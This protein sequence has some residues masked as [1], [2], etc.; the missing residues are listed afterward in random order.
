[1]FTFPDEWMGQPPP[2]ALLTSMHWAVGEIEGWRIGNRVYVPPHGQQLEYVFPLGLYMKKWGYAPKYFAF[3]K[4]SLERA[5]SGATFNRKWVRN[6]PYLYETELQEFRMA[7]KL[8][9]LDGKDKK[10]VGYHG[11]YIR[12]S[13]NSEHVA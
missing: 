9:A 10:K 12:Y 11:T 6:C 13:S 2:G 3:G 7:A 5:D 4:G 1:M 8:E